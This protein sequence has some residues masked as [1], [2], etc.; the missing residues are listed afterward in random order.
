M[1]WTSYRARS[2]LCQRVLERL[3]SEA[4]LAGVVVLVYLDDVLV[5][6][7]DEDWTWC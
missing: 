3:A 2:V 1:W 7:G 6:G 4:G 5:L